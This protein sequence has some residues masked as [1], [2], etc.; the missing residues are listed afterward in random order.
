MTR[1]SEHVIQ[2][3]LEDELAELMLNLNAEG[4]IGGTI[5]V[6]YKDGGDALTFCYKGIEDMATPATE[7]SEQ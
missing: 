4:K 6:S 5:E 1:T 2:K 3:Y 7:N